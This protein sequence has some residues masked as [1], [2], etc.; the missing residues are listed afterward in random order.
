MTNDEC[1][2]L[3]N[4]WLIIAK[5]IGDMNLNRVEFDQKKHDELMERLDIIKEQVEKYHTEMKAKLK[6]D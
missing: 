1:M 4:E 6:K 5:E 2:E 3:I